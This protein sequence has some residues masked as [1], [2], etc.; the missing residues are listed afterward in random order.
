MLVDLG[1][2]LDPPTA[3]GTLQFA[4]PAFAAYPQ[5]QR[6][7]LFVD[8][9]A[10]DPI[11]WP[12]QNLCHSLSLI[13]LSV[14]KNL[15]PGNP[16]Q[17]KGHSDSCSEPKIDVCAK[18]ISTTLLCTARFCSETA[19]VICPRTPRPKWMDDE[20]EPRSVHPSTHHIV[21]PATMMSWPLTHMKIRLR[22]G[23]KPRWRYPW[24]T[25]AAERCRLLEPA[26]RSRSLVL[27]PQ[28]HPRS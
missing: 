10:I 13:L 15:L 6:L 23:T 4:V 12:S 27:R 18:I 24:Y 21:K 25:D 16:R 8:L 14:L 9:A 17:S 22:R 20:G 19:W 3:P 28:Q 26:W 1:D 2:S 7:G 5:T 11:P